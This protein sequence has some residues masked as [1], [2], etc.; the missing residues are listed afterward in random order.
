MTFGGLPLL[1]AERGSDRRRRGCGPLCAAAAMSWMSRLVHAHWRRKGGLR[2]AV[3]V[4]R[5]TGSRRSCSRDQRQ[6]DVRQVR[7]RTRAMQLVENV[8]DQVTD[9][10]VTSL[11]RHRPLQENSLEAGAEAPTPRF[12]SARRSRTPTSPA[13]NASP[14]PHAPWSPSRAG[15]GS[16]GH[17]SPALSASIGD[18]PPGAFCARP[19]SAWA[20]TLLA[21]ESRRL[22]R[23]AL[24][25]R[26]VRLRGGPLSGRRRALSIRALGG[27]GRV[28]RWRG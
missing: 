1:P 24:S 25:R 20:A 9:G 26:S 21:K 7:V 15:A 22:A 14:R 11:T 6:R 23:P 12:G 5:Q 4:G 27:G 8:V 28:L 2:R 18:N 19:R 17:G 16:I 3:A 10:R 13:P